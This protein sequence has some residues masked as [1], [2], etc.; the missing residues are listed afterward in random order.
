MRYNGTSGI[1]PDGANIQAGDG[2]TGLGIPAGTTVT[3]IGSPYSFDG[4]L[5]V[6]MRISNNTNANADAGTTYTFS[7]GGNLLNRNFGLFTKTSVETAGISNGTTIS[8]TTSNPS[9]P[10]NSSVN[11]INLEYIGSTQ[12]Y[13]VSFNNS[14]IGTLTAGSSTVTVIFEQPP[15]AQPGETIFSFIAQPGERATVDFSELKELTNTPLGGRGTYPN[16]PDVL[17]VNIY[18]VS[19]AD[20]NANIIINWGEAQA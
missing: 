14:Y 16:G 11:T 7:R 13:R 8:P 5:E 15:F 19:G 17:A 1:G 10:G 4:N 3:S 18:K 6:V 2:I 9:F 12:Y 20:T